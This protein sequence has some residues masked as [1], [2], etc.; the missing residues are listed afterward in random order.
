[1]HLTKGLDCCGKKYGISYCL[2][3][4]LLFV[5]FSLEGEKGL[6]EKQYKLVIVCDMSKKLREFVKVVGP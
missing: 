1:M 4:A 6:V 5:C 2:V 3:S